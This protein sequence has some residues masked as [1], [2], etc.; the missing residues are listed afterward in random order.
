MGQA[1]REWTR[2]PSPNKGAALG[3]VI[4]RPS[5]VYE[6]ANRLAARVPGADLAPG[7]F[8]PIFHRLHGHGL[9][10]PEVQSVPGQQP[11]VIYHAT[12]AGVEEFEAWLRRRSELPAPRN[13]LI[14][15]IAVARPGNRGDIEAL[16][17][18][19]DEAEQDLLERIE[20]VDPAV[21]DSEA[22]G[23]WK[24]IAA[25]IAHDHA[26]AHWRAD[27][28]TVD[29]ARRRLEKQLEQFAP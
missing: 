16:I 26:L 8:Y 25:D 21:E 27:L 23:S 14:V 18:Q 24:R 7:D 20:R 2:G 11:R 9:V 4:E 12:D 29:R 1:Q 6:V 17:E 15:K 22:A 13:E 19:L 10:R 3:A 28:E 5:H